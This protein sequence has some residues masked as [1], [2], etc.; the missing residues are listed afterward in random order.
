MRNPDQRPDGAPRGQIR[1]QMATFPARKDVFRRVVD[2]IL[3]QVDRLVIVFNDYETPPAG[4]EDDPRIEAITTDVDTRDLGRFF[5]PP[6]PDDIVFLI[7]DD[8]GY[9]PD[10]V[11]RSIL[12]ASAVGWDGNAFGYQAFNHRDGADGSGP[13]W[14]QLRLSGHVPRMQGVRML[15][16]GTLVARGDAIPDIGWMMPYM[17]H[18]DVGFALH[19]LRAG[20]RGWALPR[21]AGWLAQD[22]SD[23][24]AAD[25]PLVA[26]RD[27]PALPVVAALREL[28][29]APMDHADL[30]HQRFAKLAADARGEVK[31]A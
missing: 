28:I 3:P 2:V 13:G 7:D 1:A 5:D 12:E 19:M 20:L 22:L 8:L 30:T 18:A 15:G 23:S 26:L 9:P 10:Y 27:D 6:A 14:R 11:S 21:P 29:A 16:T 25:S 17:G 24:L 31:G 4:I